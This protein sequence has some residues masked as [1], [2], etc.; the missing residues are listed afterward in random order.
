MANSARIITLPNQK[1]V[2]ND[3]GE[4]NVEEKRLH[5]EGSSIKLLPLSYNRK[6]QHRNKPPS[7]QNRLEIVNEDFREMKTLNDGSM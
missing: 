2:I 6:R 7:T 5:L 3:R 1:A 4:F